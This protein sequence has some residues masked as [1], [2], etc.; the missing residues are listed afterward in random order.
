MKEMTFKKSES[1]KVVAEIASYID[2]LGNDKEYILTIKE[3]K[4]KRSLNANAYAWTLLDKLAVKTGIGKTELYKQYVKEI[5]GNSELVCVQNKA[6]NDLISHWQAHG[7]GW[8]AET[9]TSKIK[10]CTN[11]RLYYGSSVYDT[12][13]M[14]R[15][16]NMI[17]QDCIENGIETYDADELDRLYREWGG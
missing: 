16:I 6:L 3:H 15:L 14:S 9:E 10:G 13:Q 11:V 5:G 2:S 7:I 12:A 1:I 17:V 4:Q 8:L